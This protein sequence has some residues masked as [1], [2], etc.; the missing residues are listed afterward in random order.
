M[1]LFE[2]MLQHTSVRSFTQQK[3]S[4]ELK[5]QLILAAQSA[6]SSNFL[7]AFSLIE[8]SEAEKR[9][10]IE[11]IANFPI[12]NG[13]NGSL[14]IFIAD[15]NKHS[16]VLTQNGDSMEHLRTMESL[17]VATVDA[18]LAAQSMAV[19]AESVDLGI[20]Y[21]GGIRNNLFQIKE[22]LDLPELTYPVF[23]MFVGYPAE[24][25]DVKPRLPIDSVLGTNTY[26]TFTPEM[27]RSYDEKTAAYYQARSTN[28]Q[29]TNW[30][31]K[32]RQ[33][34][35]Y[36]RRTNTVEFLKKQGFVF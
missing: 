19:Y 36:P 34:F 3:L 5:E 31:E 13:E 17:V 10:T 1:E 32:V 2:T 27:I 4:H 16:R 35:K 21:V 33:H 20:C 11:Q 22:I 25:N 15:L 9:K 28:T 18:T 7:Q 30:S 14:Y 6:S 26:R 8:I 23:G 29:E 12:D 24:K